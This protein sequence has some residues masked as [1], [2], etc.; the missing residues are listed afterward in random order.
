[1]EV[2]VY[3]LVRTAIE[4]LG[5]NMLW[6]R[7]G[8]QYGAWVLSLGDRTKT[9]EATG[10]RSF[11]ELDALYIPKIN[12]PKTWDDYQDSLVPNA[13]AQIV[14]LFG[15]GELPQD[16]S[17]QLV[18]AIESSKWKFAWTY[19]RTL[20]HEYTKKAISQVDDHS[21]IIS[22][23]EKYGIVIPWKMYKNKYLF[24][25]NRKYWHMGN[26]Y[27]S[28]PDGHPNIINRNWLDVRKH[29]E[30]VSHVWTAEEVELQMRLWEIQME[31]AA[32]K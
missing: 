30:N 32:N 9:I 13:Y 25:G 12:A 29:R 11:P 4:R 20:P 5:G 27:S 22:M 17:T 14:K 26:P 3:D 28:N 23:I 21:L 6:Q 15:L 1:M 19:A 31:K 7:E 2:R 24:F 16:E 18:N 8:F 10:K